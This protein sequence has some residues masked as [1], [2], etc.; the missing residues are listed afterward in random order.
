[1]D[2]EPG[3]LDSTFYLSRL[4]PSH[5]YLTAS[6]V[7]IPLKEDNGLVTIDTNSELP[8]DPVEFCVLLENESASP[9]IWMA[10]ARAY[11]VQGK[12]ED[13]LEVVKRGLNSD[14]IFN[15]PNKVKAA[16]HNFS[17]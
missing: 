1:M 4:D 16:F 7:N 3:A 12:I 8:D 9:E 5:N 6:T 11:A 17:H 13:G 14:V 10:I 2:D 15:S